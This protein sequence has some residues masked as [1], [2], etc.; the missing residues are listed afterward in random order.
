MISSVVDHHSSN[1]LKNSHFKAQSYLIGYK[2]RFID[3]PAENIIQSFSSKQH[4]D[5]DPFNAALLRK[6]LLST[7]NLEHRL[8]THKERPLSAA[9]IYDFGPNST[10]IRL[11]WLH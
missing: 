6:K 1:E 4:G 9:E 7:T 8:P 2:I 3:F 11:K 10:N 5:L